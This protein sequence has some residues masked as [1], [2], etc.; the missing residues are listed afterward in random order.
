MFRH[1]ARV[2]MIQLGT[3]LE[4]VVSLPRVLGACQD[5]TREFAGRRPRLTGRLSGDFAKGIGKIARNTSGD[6]QRKIVRLAIGNVGGCQITGVSD[7]TAQV[8]EQL[9]MAELPRTVVEPPVP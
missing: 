1:R 7:G 9:T 5:G 2:R 4:C 3:R 6:P 8:L